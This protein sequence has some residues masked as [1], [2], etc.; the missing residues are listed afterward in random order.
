MFDLPPPSSTEP[1]PTRGTPLAE[2]ITTI[3]PSLT[4]PP[5]PPKLTQQPQV[6]AALITGVISLLVAIVGIVPA[7]VEA[8]KD[9]PTPTPPAAVVVATS[10]PTNTLVAQVEPTLAPTD[11]PAPP[12]DAPVSQPNIIPVGATSTSLPVIGSTPVLA[13]PQPTADTSAST[14][15]ETAAQ[16]PNIRMFFDNRS[17]TIRNQGGGRKSLIGVTFY[18]DEGRWDAS[19]WGPIHEKFTNKDCLRM[20]DVSTGQQS[21]PSECQD[22]LA[23]LL[24]GPEVIFWR[25]EDGFHVERSGVELGVCTISPCDLYLPPN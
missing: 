1:T 23:L 11:T 20:R 9:D 12:T 5:P 25:D 17:F 8:A 19:Q 13:D 16:E 6:M 4:Q 15:N 18:S 22:L 24:V 14:S 21:P 7:L 10:A 2:P 3:P